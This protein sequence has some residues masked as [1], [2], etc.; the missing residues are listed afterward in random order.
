[1][2]TRPRTEA[3]RK[4]EE[5]WKSIRG[6]GEQVP[7]RSAF[8][9][10]SANAAILPFMVILEVVEGD[11]VFRLAGTGLAEHQGLDITGR[12]YGEFAAADQVTR[13]VARIGA[14]HERPCGFSS[15]H[16][17]EY[18]RG[19]ASEV[20]VTGFP[21]RGDGG[22][23]MMVL[24]VTPVGRGLA[25]R[26]DDPLYMKPAS[27]IDF[28]DLGMGAPDDAAILKAAADTTDMDR[29]AP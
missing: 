2:T 24:V 10:T 18:G 26:R 16:I 28:I 1:M 9:V 14:C 25:T 7:L 23:R 13:A 11:I 8:K 6:D 5:Y 27:R 29:G 21:L 3:G 20:D 17:E 19:I 12:R 15:L 22:E 4:L